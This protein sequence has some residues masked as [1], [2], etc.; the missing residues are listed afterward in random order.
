MKHEITSYNT[1]KM[2]SSALKEAL[3]QKD[4]SKVSISEVAEA[5]NLNRKTFY[6]HFESINDLVFWTLNDGLLKATKSFDLKDDY[7][8]TIHFALDYIEKDRAFMYKLIHSDARGVFMEFVF[9]NLREMTMKAIND[10][11]IRNDRKLEE[12]YKNFI[13]DFSTQAMVGTIIQ[14]IDDP[15][16]YNRAE[17]EEYLNRVF[18]I[19]I[20]N[21][22]KSEA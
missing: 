6:Y 14:R 9:N 2:L 22:T 17:I 13:A 10:M 4:L 3:Q 11:S 8:K 20:E 15:K 16:R 19:T 5:A 1:R 18:T 21:L 7:E 12:N